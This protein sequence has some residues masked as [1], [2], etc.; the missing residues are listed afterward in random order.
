MKLE[1]L[2][3]KRALRGILPEALVTVVNVQWYGDNA[4]EPT[5]NGA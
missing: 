2:Q 3:P 1:D 5:E 4:L